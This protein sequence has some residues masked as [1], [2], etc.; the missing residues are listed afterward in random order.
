MPE[1][2]DTIRFDR[3]E[4]SGASGDLG[5]PA[6]IPRARL[7]AFACI[8]LVFL[9]ILW[10]ERAYVPIWDGQVYA[11][12]VIDAARAGLSFESLRCAR[13]PTQ[14]WA[15]VLA[16]P[17][18]LRIGDVRLLHLTDVLLGLLALACIRIALQRIFP[19]PTLGFQLDLVTLACAVHPVVLSTLVQ[20]NI[21]FGVY[22]F[23]FAALA[24]LLW[25]RF[26]WTAVAGLLL[27]FS[28]E[29]GVLVYAVLIALD[30]AFRAFGG[31]GDWR[32]RFRRA[33]R[34]WVTVLPLVV[35]V[36][37]V[38]VWNATHPDPAVWKHGWQKETIDGF[39]FFDLN[40]PVFRSYA[41]GIFVIGFMWVVSGIILA[42]LAAGGL[43]MARRQPPRDV[44][45]ADRVCVAYLSVLTAV[46]TYLLTSFRTWSN[47][48]Y[49]ALLYPLFVL[50]AFAALVRLAVPPRVRAWMLGAIAALFL[51]AAFR[52]AD[53]ISSL[54]YGT[55]PI[56]ERT[57]YRMASITA[58]MPAPAATS[59]CT[60]SSSP[61]I[62][63]SRTRFSGAC[64]RPT[65]RS[66]SPRASCGGTS[67]VPSIRSRTSAR[68]ARSAASRRATATRPASPGWAT[69]ESCGSWS[70]RTT[71]I[72][73]RSS[74]SSPA[75]P[76]MRWAPS[77]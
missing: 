20:V 34:S 72:G 9:A 10:P 2:A 74:R 43:R 38:R 62:T 42:D 8:G 67:G 27:C 1:G 18:F 35:F 64:D 19:G 50:L 12:C 15:V 70:S 25:E 49:F 60:T 55:F 36:V 48:R 29:T 28:K 13:H 17:Q 77:A 16:V 61:A 66:S 30:A 40:D 76:G 41:A 3:N 37:H 31:R 26:A 44:P 56:G 63:T 69:R 14:A 7:A 71:P 24:A 57:M 46:L 45:G 22:V 39:K 33:L 75:R 32:D 58:S 51:L 6:T 73:T 47:L 4:V 54:T 65:R 53:P 52:S 68:C 5:T 21:D 59:S 11:S 23:F